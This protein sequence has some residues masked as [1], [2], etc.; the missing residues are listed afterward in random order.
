MNSRGTEALLCHM[1]MFI[2]VALRGCFKR[3]LLI[4]LIVWLIVRSTFEVKLL[5]LDMLDCEHCLPK[6]FLIR[7]LDKNLEES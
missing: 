7:I 6:K 4:K 5:F 2:D 1:E 3:M